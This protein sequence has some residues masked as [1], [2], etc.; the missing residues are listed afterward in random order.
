MK[1]V[2][3]KNLIYIVSIF[4]T[5]FLN[6]C[7]NCFADNKNVSPLPA[8]AQAKNKKSNSPVYPLVVQDNEILLRGA[9]LCPN[10]LMV[11]NTQLSP[12]GDVLIWCAEPPKSHT[13][14]KDEQPTTEIISEISTD[15]VDKTNL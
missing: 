12:S 8:N 10:S 11:I 15:P 13:K 5:L 7:N 2:N 14:S 4:L 3:Y 1:R 6:A 9:E